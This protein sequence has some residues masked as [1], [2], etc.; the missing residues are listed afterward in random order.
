MGISERKKEI[1][2]RRHRSQKIQKVARKAESAS[3]SEKQ[4]L[5][6]KIRGLTPGADIIIER[7]KLEER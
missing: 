6:E 1:R 2:R 7:L 4:Q 5:A 3:P